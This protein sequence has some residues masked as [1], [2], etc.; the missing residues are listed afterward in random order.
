MEFLKKYWWMFL[1]KFLI[2]L[3]NNNILKAI[4]ITVESQIYCRN[5]VISGPFAKISPR[6]A[7]SYLKRKVELKLIDS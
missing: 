3:R 1:T 5:W 2:F 7:N 4:F 6:N